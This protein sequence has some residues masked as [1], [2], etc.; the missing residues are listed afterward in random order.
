MALGRIHDSPTPALPEPLR[1][2]VAG[3]FSSGKSTAINA[4]L[5]HRLLPSAFGGL[6]APPI[7]IRH[8]DS[9]AVSYPALDGSQRPA[10]SILDAIETGVATEIHVT[11]PFPALRGVELIE[12][13]A[14]ADG[15]WEDEARA[16][17]ASADMLIWCSI[18]SQAWRLSEKSF[19]EDLPRGLRSRSVLL[20][21]RADKLR[22]NADCDKIMRRLEREA[23][24]YF[25]NV[26]FM[27]GAPDLIEASSRDETAWADTGGKYILDLAQELF[28]ARGEAAS[29]AFP[30]TD[31]PA[32]P[33]QVPSIE[34]RSV[35]SAP[36]ALQDI[37]APTASDWAAIEAAQEA[38]GSDPAVTDPAPVPDVRAVQ[39]EPVLDAPDRGL[40]E[41]PAPED[42]TPEAQVVLFKPH[43]RDLPRSGETG[44]DAA[45][46]R[47]G[48][49]AAADVPAVR[50]APAAAPDVARMVSDLDG[51]LAAGVVQTGTGEILRCYNG[52][53]SEVRSLGIAAALIVSTQARAMQLLR[54]TEP[55]EEVLL[56]HATTALLIRPVDVRAERFVFALLRRDGSNIPVAR[57]VLREVAEILEQTPPAEDPA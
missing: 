52:I 30:P 50:P 19:I 31:S 46:R 55:A 34:R 44:A 21:S 9:F 39:A 14:R 37:P 13:P 57:V 29:A 35:T 1:L 4:V 2:V 26:I 42:A 8:G 45:F 36:Q 25:A 47:S 40:Q 18:S 17:V 49:R 15:V 5:R 43:S 23:A 54:Q 22:S 41:G 27:G 33:R 38:D 20:L 6:K 53:E 10:D 3:E 24:S 12:V 28:G 51:V 48:S 56:T 7:R 11:V 16:L 32:L